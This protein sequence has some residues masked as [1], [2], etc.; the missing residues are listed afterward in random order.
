MNGAGFYSMIQL[1]TG[2]RL[3][4]YAVCFCESRNLESLQAVIEA[5]EELQSAGI[6]G[7]NALVF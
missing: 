1:L 5:A 3:V 6:M 2:A 7:F 4:G